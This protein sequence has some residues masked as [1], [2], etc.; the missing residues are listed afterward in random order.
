MHKTSRKKTPAE[1][2]RQ[3]VDRLPAGM[4]TVVEAL[5]KALKTL[6]FGPP[7]AYVYNPLE[8]A[9]K[10]YAC[11]LQRYGQ[12]P[13]EVIFVG[14]NPG[15]WGMA[16]TGI[17]FGDVE[18]AKEWL[19]IEVAVG[20]PS[21]VHPKRPVFCRQLL[22][23]PFSG[24]KRPKQNPGPARRLGTGAA[25]RCLRRCFAQHGLL[26][27]APFCRRRRRLCREASPHCFGRHGC[28]D[29]RDHPSQ[30][31][32]PQGESRLGVF[33]RQ[34]IERHWHSVLKGEPR[35]AVAIHGHFGLA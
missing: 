29:R 25:G 17:P 35:L 7:V 6:R 18:I 2:S 1:G 5:L 31:G 10:A 19:G 34:G 32:E 9:G 11:Y 24:R 14:M 8:Y 15:P 30:P 26:V 28:R 16:Q 13:K 20:A 12:R 21:S 3:K 27:G 23:S 22:S 4:D 33:D